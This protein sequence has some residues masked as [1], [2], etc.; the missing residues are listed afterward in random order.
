MRRYEQQYDDNF[1]DATSL[2]LLITHADDSRGSKAFN[3]VC[4]CDSVCVCPH[5]KTKTAE[6][7]ITKL[8]TEIVHHEPCVMYRPQP[9]TT[10]EAA[11]PPTRS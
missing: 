7:T 3:G 2:S 8:A 10:A 4:V 1:V 6:T 9:D 11:I 5:D